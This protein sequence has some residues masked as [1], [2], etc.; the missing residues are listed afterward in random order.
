M[1]CK[2]TREVTS[3]WLFVAGFIG[4]VQLRLSVLLC[5]GLHVL[6]CCVAAMVMVWECHVAEGPCGFFFFCSVQLENV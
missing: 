1:Q 3:V 6:L 2:V 4:E 5:N